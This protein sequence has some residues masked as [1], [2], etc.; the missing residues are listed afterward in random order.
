[1]ATPNDLRESFPSL[2]DA[3]TGAGVPLTKSV[4]GDAASGKVGSVG[5]AYKDSNGNIVLPQ[6]NDRGQ[7]PVTLETA[8]T[9]SRMHGGVPGGILTTAASGYGNFQTVC[10][11]NLSANT[12]V[13]DFAGKVS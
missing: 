9:R 10:S 3:S 4:E 12:Q 11:I 6:L 13:G 5:F 1:M 7:L 2:E 8:G